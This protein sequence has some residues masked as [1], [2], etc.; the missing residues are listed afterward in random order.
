VHSTARGLASHPQPPRAHLPADYVE[1]ER[2]R[3]EMYKRLAEVREPA[4]LEAVLEELTDRYGPPPEVVRNLLAVAA[5][6]IK[7]R[8]AGLTEIV[9]SG[10]YLRF[11]PAELPESRVLRLK[12]LYPGSVVKEAAKLI[13]V[14]RPRPRQIG[15]P[16]IRDAELLAWCS[17]VVESVFAGVP[18]P[19]A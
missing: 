12:R 4:E 9:T 5:F 19:V 8:A 15:G 6:R 13:L 10:N 3:L 18:Q 11:A 16:P 14:P 2:L 17:E 7:A 1:S